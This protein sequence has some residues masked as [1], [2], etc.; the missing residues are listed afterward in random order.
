[1]VVV[2]VV[3]VVADLL[4]LLMWFFRS[5]PIL[6]NV[7]RYRALTKN[8]LV[9]NF[10]ASFVLVSCRTLGVFRKVL[11]SIQSSAFVG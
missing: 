2:V 7:A 1:M 3:V 4:W 6:Q 8:A 10:E 5:G 9:L 11:G